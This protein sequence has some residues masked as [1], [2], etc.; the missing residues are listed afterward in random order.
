MVHVIRDKK[1]GKEVQR[2]ED[3]SERGFR[4]LLMRID[5]KRF[6]VDIYSNKEN[7]DKE[8]QKQAGVEP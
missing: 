6:K 7:A 2:F 1:T 4:G 5:S 3:L 8:G